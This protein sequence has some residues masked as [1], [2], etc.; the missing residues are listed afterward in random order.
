MESILC[1]RGSEIR[2][3]SCED[4]VLAR[5]MVALRPPWGGGSVK[6][7]FTNLTNLMSLEQLH[8]KPMGMYGGGLLD[9]ALGGK[10][11]TTIHS[12]RFVMALLQWHNVYTLGEDELPDPRG[13]LITFARY[14][15]CNEMM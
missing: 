1:E 9:M 6:L 8:H 10:E 2:L 11:T 12:H 15:V 3:K 13:G 5:L 4:E 14:S 7:I